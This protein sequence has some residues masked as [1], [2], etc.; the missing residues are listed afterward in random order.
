MRDQKSKIRE[1]ITSSSKQIAEEVVER[2]YAMNPERWEKYGSKG[3]ELS[4]RDAGYHLPFLTESIVSGDENIFTEYVA[5]VRKLFNGLGLPSD[6]MK[7]TLQLTGESL[8]DH[9]SNDQLDTVLPYINAGIEKLENELKPDVPFINPEAYLGQLA[10]QY[11]ESLLQGDRLTA[12]KLILEAVESG[13]PVRDIYLHVFKKSQYEVGR[14]W[15]SN[16]ITV[17]KEH[18]CSAATQQIMSQLYPHIFSTERKGRTFVAACIGGELHEIGIRMV[19]DFF[20]MDGWD[21]YYLGANSPA[22]SIIQ[23]I[24]DNKADIVGLS[25]AM[26]YHRELMRETIQDIRKNSKNNV[27]IMV[28][29]NALNSAKKKQESFDADAYAPDAV[30]AVQIANQM[31]KG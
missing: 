24:E 5:W 25:A 23:A 9:L 18:F 20:E 17:A 4:I 3:K 12:S 21:T 19:A 26:P 7:T 15:L 27:R 16:K 1:I 10:K 2:Q 29:G 22:S 11:N 14:L 13:T 28:G 6:T 8:K 31:M 30:N